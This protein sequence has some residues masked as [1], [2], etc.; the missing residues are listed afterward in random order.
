M[1]VGISSEN[2]TCY[3]LDEGIELDVGGGPKVDTVVPYSPCLMCCLQDEVDG[4]NEE[5]SLIQGSILL[6]K[7]DTLSDCCEGS[8]YLT[9]II[10]CNLMVVYLICMGGLRVLL[11]G[12]RLGVGANFISL[13]ASLV[14]LEFVKDLNNIPVRIV[15]YDWQLEI[16]LHEIWGSL[17]PCLIG[18]ACIIVDYDGR[19]S[20]YILSHKPLICY[21]QM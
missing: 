19:S 7:L 15:L 4:K 8:I 14:G 6:G 13:I 3:P 21:I 9:I 11:D 18:H 10:L 16:S 20:G 5:V 17:S 2:D 12:M 1:L